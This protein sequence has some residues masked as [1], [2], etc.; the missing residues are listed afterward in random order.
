MVVLAALLAAP[1]AYAASQTFT[2]GV[3]DE[4]FWSGTSTGSPAVEYALDLTGSGERLRVGF[5][6]ATDGD[7]WD[8][9]VE[10]P[11]GNTAFTPGVGLYSQEGVVENPAAGRWTVR[12]TGEAITDPKFRMR[13]KL[14]G[15]L[16][17][18]AGRV[19]LAPNL[20]ALPPYEFT[21]DTPVTNG[22]ATGQEPVGQPTPGGRAACHP[23]EVAEEQAVRCLRMAF[24]VRN[25]G[26]GPMQ[27][28]TRGAPFPLDQELVQSVVYSDGTTE[29][30]VA[31]VAKFHKT[32]E[33][34]HHD[35][36][37]SL[38]LFRVVDG[39]DPARPALEP[40][41][42][43]HM[44][45]FAHRNELL[46]E[47]RR[48]YPLLGFDGFGL[49]GGWGDYY[50]WDRPGNYIDF[51]ING[52]GRYVL[53]MVADPVEGVLESN[54]RDNTAYSLID[55]AGEKV[56]WLASGRGSDP[57]DPCRI[58]MPMGA[59]PEPADADQPIRPASCAPDTTW[60]E[61]VP[62]SP[63]SAPAPPVAAAPKPVA[64]AKRPLTKKQRRAAAKR[65]AL[66]R[67]LAACKKRKSA[68]SRRSCRARA[69]RS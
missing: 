36:A 6:H 66:A 22:G 63:A 11:N 52:D 19:A 42:A 49:K 31:G 69:R 46:R 60:A 15:P 21:F 65:R 53:R 40:A 45:G 28:S 14:E 16:L 27:L 59:E 41:S 20:Q 44:K 23:E 3:G 37:I 57:W 7:V 67:R 32:H 24:G 47:W 13:A 25:T 35:K 5:D 68:R 34:Y 50:E 54:E 26:M 30:R 55:V 56:T 38:Q 43:V 61:L 17:L 8:I 58:L 2:L 4:A 9:V 51:G 48:F 64:N 12:V 33:H 62:P 18:P 29:E 1:S 39:P 10:G